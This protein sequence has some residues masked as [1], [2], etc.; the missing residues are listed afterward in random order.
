VPLFYALNSYLKER[1]LES[2]IV[3]EK[4]PLLKQLCRTRH[5]LVRQ[6]T[7]LKNRIKRDI[8]MLFP[9][10]DKC[11]EIVETYEA[12]DNS[13]SNITTMYTLKQK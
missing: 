12:T 7:R 5:K 9:E 2:N 3:P 1:N 6:K 4:Y 10:Y 13:Y 11:F 8:H